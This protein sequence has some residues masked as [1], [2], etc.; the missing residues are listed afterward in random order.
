M[1]LELVQQL[2]NKSI[3]NSDTV[4]VYQPDYVREGLG[5]AVN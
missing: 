1:I 2:L 4:I 3:P 5:F